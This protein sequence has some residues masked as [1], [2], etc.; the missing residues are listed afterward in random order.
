MASRFVRLRSAGQELNRI[1]KQWPASANYH[2]KLVAAFSANRYFFTVPEVGDRN[3][4]PI[5]MPGQASERGSPPGTKQTRYS[6]LT[7]LSEATVQLKAA[8]DHLPARPVN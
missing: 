8:F 4:T 1:A 3:L 5:I 2:L 7:P 6:R